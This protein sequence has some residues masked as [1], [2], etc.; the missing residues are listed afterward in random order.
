MLIMKMISRRIELPIF[1]SAGFGTEY[2]FTKSLSLSGFVKVKYSYA[3][4]N[5]EWQELQLGVETNKGNEEVTNSSVNY[6]SGL[7]L[8]FFF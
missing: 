3:S 4:S 6:K 2:F 8:T 5:Y 1:V 7:G